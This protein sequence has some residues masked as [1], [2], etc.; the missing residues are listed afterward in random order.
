MFRAGSKG[1]APA[2][3]PVTTRG[4]GVGGNQFLG[5]GGPKAGDVKR[6]RDGDAWKD[7]CLVVSLEV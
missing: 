3:R 4:H 6:C 1:R 7:D 2:R 5:R